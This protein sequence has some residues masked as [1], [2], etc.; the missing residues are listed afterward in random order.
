ML[1]WFHLNLKFKNYSAGTSVMPSS[2]GWDKHIKKREEIIFSLIFWLIVNDVT[3]K[4]LYGRN[5]LGCM[6]TSKKNLGYYSRD[7]FIHT[8][9]KCLEPWWSPPSAWMGSTMMP[10]TGQPIFL[11][12][13]RCSS[14]LLKHLSS[15]CNGE[16][17]CHVKL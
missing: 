17:L 13:S 6:K 3:K 1:L 10:A 15:S 4:A 7:Y 8:W 5:M 14:T 11:W 9:K 16:P 2:A 12:S